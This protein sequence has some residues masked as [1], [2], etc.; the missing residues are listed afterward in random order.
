M[1]K[2]FTATSLGLSTAVPL[3]HCAVQGLQS[4]SPRLFDQTDI[5]DGCSLH[6]VPIK[7]AEFL[8]HN[9]MTRVFAQYP[10]Y[11]STELEAFYNLVLHVPSQA[12]AA[13]TPAGSYEVYVVSL[14]IA[15]SLST[16]AR[17]QLGLSRSIAVG[18][19]RNA[20]QQLPVILS[21]DLKGLQA[22]LLLLQYTF[23][24]PDMANMWLLSG[25]ASQACI[26]L[27][28]HKELPDSAEITVAERDMRRRIFW[29][30]WE[31]ETAISSVLLRPTSFLNAQVDVAFPTEVEDSA[32]TATGIDPSGRLSKFTARRIW[33]FRQLES[34]IVSILC[35][36]GQ[37]PAE[38]PSLGEWMECTEQA[39]LNWKLEV[40]RSAAANTDI[41]LKPRWAEMLLYADIAYEQLIVALYR[42]CPR[43]KHPRPEN[44]MKAFDASYKVADGYFE[45]ANLDFGSSKYVFGPCHHSFSSAMTF[46]QALQRCKVEISAKYTLAEVVGFMSSF[47]RLFA[48]TA[49]RWPTALRFLEEYERVLASIKKEYITFIVQ[50]KPKVTISQ[51]ELV[52]P[53]DEVQDSVLDGPMDFDDTFIFGSQ[54]RPEGFHDVVDSDESYY[55]MPADWNAEFDFGMI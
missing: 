43:V 51:P 48:T 50:S 25:F 34:E 47:S 28:L 42:P 11:A 17:A 27:G 32:I 40:H 45:Q 24:E 31:M 2:D 23:L 52:L 46:I 8:Y 39:V 14:I 13:G 6:S 16:A 26:D 19:V 1:T 35:H 20:I 9:F 29:C 36:N 15:I 3:L 49:E 10:I 37:L 53:M 5:R 7:V 55:A 21:N 4:P 41:A 33:G 22:V 54:F 38:T 44:F 30:A 12:S 18:L